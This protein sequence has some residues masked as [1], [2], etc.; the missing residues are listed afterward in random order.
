MS[1]IIT[2]GLGISSSSLNI[3]GSIEIVEIIDKLEIIDET[4]EEFEIIQL[5]K[6]KKKDQNWGKE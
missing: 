2:R 5:G 4:E 3:G 1:L 6:P